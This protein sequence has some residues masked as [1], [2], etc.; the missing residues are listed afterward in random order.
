MK[1]DF[2][3]SIAMYGRYN[4]MR[5]AKEKGKMLLQHLLY[6][7]VSFF[8]ELAQARNLKPAQAKA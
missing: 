1:A 3:M 5:K 7:D 2:F 4:G 6:E 8:Y